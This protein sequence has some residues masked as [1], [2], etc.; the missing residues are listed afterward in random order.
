MATAGLAVALAAC[1]SSSSK[2][3]SNAPASTSANT[4]SVA[5]VGGLSNVLVDAS[6]RPLYSPDQEASGMVHCTGDCTSVWKPLTPGSGAPTAAAGVPTP[7]VVSRPD[8]SQQVAVAGK[9]LYTFVQDSPGQLKGNGATDAF[10]GQQF[11]WHAIL[12]SGAAAPSNAPA[13][14]A[15]GSGG[16]NY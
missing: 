3:S 1:G 14:T 16:Y 11:T 5:K 4:V 9:P 13:T 6:G 15:S 12:A 7:T 10:G 2:S 8:G